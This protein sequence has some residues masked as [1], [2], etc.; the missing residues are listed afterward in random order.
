MKLRDFIYRKDGG[1]TQRYSC[2][3]LNETTDDM[4]GISMGE[5]T[6]EEREQVVK[7]VREFE[8]KIDPFMKNFRKFK[9]EKVVDL[10]SETK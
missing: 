5:L 10:L 6:Q 9:K 1:V 3:V 8:S 2:M 4:S 7:A